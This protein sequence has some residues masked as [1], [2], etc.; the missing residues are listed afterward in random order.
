VN[1]Y[2]KKTEG[3]EKHSILFGFQKG[4]TGV[5]KDEAAAPSVKGKEKT[6]LSKEPSPEKKAAAPSGP[7]LHQRICQKGNP[8]W[9]PTKRAG[10]LSADGTKMSFGEKE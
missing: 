2:T 7:T 5:N 8:L 10:Y 1:S 9:E 4:T 3:Q 6:A